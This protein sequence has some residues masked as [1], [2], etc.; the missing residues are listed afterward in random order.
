MALK[1]R[2]IVGFVYFGRLRTSPYKIKLTKRCFL[3]ASDMILLPTIAG[4]EITCNSISIIVSMMNCTH[5]FE[6]FQRFAIQLQT[7]VQH[8][9]IVEIKANILPQNSSFI[10]INLVNEFIKDRLRIFVG[11]RFQSGTSKESMLRGNMLPGGS[12]TRNNNE[13]QTQAQLSRDN[14]ATA[15]QH[16]KAR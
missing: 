7:N 8:S 15:S 16:L 14:R 4:A 3:Y 12:D 6:E 1:R 9:T 10:R 11:F 2:I 5:H 13:D